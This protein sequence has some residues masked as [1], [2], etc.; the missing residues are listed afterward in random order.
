MLVRGSENI[1]T[2]MT[3][4]AFPAAS[5]YALWHADVAEL[6]DAAGLGPAAARR[7]GSSPF[8]RTKAL[9]FVFLHYGN[10]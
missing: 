3:S 6:V 10:S 2:W 4:L 9:R 1:A 5:D 8:I 7:G